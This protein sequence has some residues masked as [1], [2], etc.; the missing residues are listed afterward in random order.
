MRRTLLIVLILL[1]VILL[2]GSLTG[3]VAQYGFQQQQQREM[4]AELD[5]RATQAAGLA[6]E[7]ATLQPAARALQDAGAAQ[8]AQIAT[9]EAELT[10]PFRPSPTPPT[11]PTVTILA[12]E[13][14]AQIAEGEIL[15]IRWTAHN[16]DRIG[17]VTLRV[18]GRPV[19]ET[20]LDRAPTAEG[21]FQ[22]IAAGLG[23]HQ[24]EV[25]A[26]NTVGMESVP[27]SITVEV[28]PAG[29]QS[30]GGISP[31][32]AALMDQIEGQVA[33]LRGLE[34]LQPVTRTVLTRDDLAQYLIAELDE[35]LSPAEAEQNT[36][37]M[38][39]LDLVLLDLDLRALLEG[40]YT[41]QIAG[42][43]DTDTRSFTLVDEDDEMS[44]FDRTVYAHEF[45][46]ALQDQHYDLDA[47]TSDELNDDAALA[48]DALIEG[49][50]T[51][52]MQLYMLEHLTSD[53]LF[54]MLA[55]SVE[56]ESP[57]L[58]SAP[59][60]IR[61]QFN[62]PYE[63]GLVFAQVLFE[64]G[65]YAA[66]DAVFANPPQST[67]QVLHP[68]RYL[69]G[70]EPI[71]VSLPPLTD[72]LGSGWR[73]VDENVLGEFGLR[74]YLEQ[75]VS[76]K[77]AAAAADGWGGDWYSVYFND[78][79]QGLVLVLQVVWDTQAEAAE[80]L[81][82]YRTF[83]KVRFAADPERGADGDLCWIGGDA[84]CMYPGR[85][86]DQTLIIRA[87]QPGMVDEVRALFPEF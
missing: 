61:A 66:V 45:V 24:L 3:N 32:N 55:E 87:P 58:D 18:D 74:A 71:S 36:I 82:A 67:E 16:P 7:L 1:L 64:Q 39:A 37:E 23:E 14:G 70:E 15:V 42:F 51:L 10:R 8:A 46:H 6:S 47:L 84:I 68:A 78:Q 41:E 56:Y 85:T 29:S 63:A 31:E 53:E 62:F 48:V 19:S 49:D 43:Y 69:A 25:V 38:A 81:Q 44:P 20:P 9:L 28:V 73:L 72:T 33:A 83:G 35:E 5:A 4:Q 13:D 77:T 86:G 75:Q 27:A 17:R 59:A 2:A 80:F 52:L 76:S 22:W 34:P 50:A 30:S 26:A 79:T 60:A 21:Q 40:L 12:P 11:I 65:G 54:E 57:L